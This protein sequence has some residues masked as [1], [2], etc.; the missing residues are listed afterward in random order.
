MTI[1]VFIT[2]FAPENVNNYHIASNNT[3]TIKEDGGSLGKDLQGDFS[4][5]MLC[6]TLQIEV[7]Q[8]LN[9]MRKDIFR[10]LGVFLTLPNAW[11]SDEQLWSRVNLMIQD[12]LNRLR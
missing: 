5:G 1:R 12:Y 3:Y 6:H 2:Y 7:D 9:K 4:V 8:C 10:K 11:A